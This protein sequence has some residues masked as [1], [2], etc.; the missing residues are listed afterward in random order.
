LVPLAKI[1]SAPGEQ[2]LLPGVDLRGVDVVLTGEL[3]DR[4][5]GFVGGQ[6]DLGLEP[7]RM[8]LS[9]EPHGFPSSGPRVYLN[10]WSRKR[11][12]LQPAMDPEKATSPLRQS[13]GELA[14]VDQDTPNSTGPAEPAVCRKFLL[15]DAMILLAGLALSMGAYLFVFLADS[16][17]RFAHE[18]ADSVWAVS[19]DPYRFWKAIEP[20]LRNTM[21]HGLQVVEMMLAGL[22][23]AFFIIR[24]RQP[25]PPMRVLIRQPGTVA[26]MAAVLGLFWVTGWLHLVFPDQMRAETG[27]AIAAGGSVA[28]AWIVL[29]FS[30]WG[31]SEPGWIDRMGRL[32][33]IAL[34]TALFL[35]SIVFRV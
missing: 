5:V 17:S 9:L 33:G 3:V 19:F 7:R 15:S 10:H 28:V 25:R 21:W 23:P 31:L 18:L 2:L 11:G 13:L 4:P 29:S 27:A 22:V 32:I 34:L 30:G 1:A 12:P 26:T 16:C 14:V 6:G 35:G 20:D 8:N 24:L